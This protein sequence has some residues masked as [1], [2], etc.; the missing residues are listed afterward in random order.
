MEKDIQIDEHDQYNREGYVM[1]EDNEI[2]L[3]LD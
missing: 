3:C 1:G 2:R